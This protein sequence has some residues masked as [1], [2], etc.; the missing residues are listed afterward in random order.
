MVPERVQGT[1]VGRHGMVVEVA[2]H[3]PPQP[4][5]LHGDR[6][7][8]ALPQLLLDHPQLRLHAV[9]PALPPKLGIMP[10]AGLAT[11][12]GKTQEVESLRLAEHRA[13]GGS[14]AATSTTMP[15]RPT[16][17]PWTRSGTMSPTSGGA[18]YGVAVRRIG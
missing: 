12:E 8:H 14:W 15:C 7:V 10:G 13:A 9:P 16:R 2:A 18:R 11:D 3:D 5:P 17:V 1:R 4:A 6:L